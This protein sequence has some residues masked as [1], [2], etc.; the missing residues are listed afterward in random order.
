MRKSVV[1]VVLALSLVAL[2]AIT[3]GPA[4]ACCTPLSPGYWMNHP[5]AWPCSTIT[6]GGVTYSQAEAI[7]LMS[8]P[9]KGDKTLTMFQALAAAELNRL[10]GC[11]SISAIGSA[12]AW[13]A[14]HHAGSGVAGSSD[15]WQ[16]GGECLYWALDAWNNG[17]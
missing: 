12:Q 14:A 3:A 10:S 5:E 16:C 7:A 6:I 17:Y 2:F 4:L 1:V 11:G 15:A 8:A 9:T 13:M